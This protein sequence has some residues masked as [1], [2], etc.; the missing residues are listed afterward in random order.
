MSTLEGLINKVTTA[1]QADAS[2]DNPE[3]HGE[4]L[5]S[6]QR[7]TLAAETPTETAKRILY[8]VIIFI[9]R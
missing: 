8:Q 3:A 5:R 1:A 9:Y 2:R 4:L 7:L 6:I